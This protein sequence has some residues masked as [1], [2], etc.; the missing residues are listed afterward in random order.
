M[1][2]EYLA[3][4]EKIRWNSS[5][6]IMGYVYGEDTDDQKKTHKFLCPYEELTDKMSL[7]Y[8]WLVV[9]NSFVEES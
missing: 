6:E 9:R 1:V 7:H 5:H 3:I 4:G 8:D 2:M